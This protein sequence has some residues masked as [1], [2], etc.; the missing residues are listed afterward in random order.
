[1]LAFSSSNE[2]L[3]VTQT[4]E[5]LQRSGAA[6]NTNAAWTTL[7]PNTRLS[8]Q[9]VDKAQML[10]FLSRDYRIFRFAGGQFTELSPPPGLAGKRVLT[11][12]A[13][14]RGRVWAGTD[15]EVA[16]WDGRRFE[17]M[18]PTNGEASLEASYI[19]PTRDGGL[20][21]LA[22]GRLRKQGDG[23]GPPRRRR[24]GA[25]WGPPPAASWAC[26]RTAR[27]AYGFL[28]TAMACSM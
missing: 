25:C 5:V 21:V 10:W 7:A 13:D 18:T 28:I 11:L 2:V 20:W 23:N 24:G 4:G 8:F 15:Q 27:A 14:A 6:A 19:L 26:T 22:G 12:A 3:F 1:M 9:C 17:T 16:L